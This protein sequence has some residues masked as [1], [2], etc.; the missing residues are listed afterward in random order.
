[1][2]DVRS[3]FWALVVGVGLVD[4]VSEGLRDDE[5]SFSV[6]NGVVAVDDEPVPVRVWVPRC[7]G[8]RNDGDEVDEGGE[9]VVLLLLKGFGVV[10]SFVVIDEVTGPRF[11]NLPF[12]EEYIFIPGDECVLLIGD[13]GTGREAGDD[14][15]CFG[16]TTF[17]YCFRNALKSRGEGT[18]TFLDVA[19]VGVEAAVET[20]DGAALDFADVES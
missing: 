8:F 2:N 13:R 14:F 9:V 10:G 4:G 7:C 16:G 18:A 20:R 17:G 11:M 19:P 6:K 15:S 5:T 12:G 3:G 1:M